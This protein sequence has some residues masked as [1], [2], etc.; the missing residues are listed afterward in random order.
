MEVNKNEN[1]HIT[2]NPSYLRISSRID[3]PH[4]N[5]NVGENAIF[6]FVPYI[7]DLLLQSFQYIYI[8][9]QQD[10][11]T[12]KKVSICQLFILNGF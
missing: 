12:Y 8:W 3:I 6:V 1:N 7:G 9:I 11:D 10:G 4:L 2:K 5:E